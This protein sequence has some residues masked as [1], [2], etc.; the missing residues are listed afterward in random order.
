MFDSDVPLETKNPLADGNQVNR[1]GSIA[2]MFDAEVASEITKSRQQQVKAESLETENGQEGTEDMDFFDIIARAL[3]V[4]LKLDPDGIEQHLAGIFE[5]V[6][7]KSELMPADEFLSL[8]ESRLKLQLTSDEQKLLIHQV[9]G[10]RQEAKQNDEQISV[11]SLLEWWATFFEVETVDP[12]RAAVLAM[13]Q[14]NVI[15]PSSDFRGKWDLIQA[16]LLFYIACMLPYR[17]GFDHDVV[18]WSAWF[19]LDLVIDLYFVRL[20]SPFLAHQVA[21]MH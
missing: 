10:D 4:G 9:Q 2:N 12:F 11:A 18:L 5:D 19:W 1:S 20:C 17:I 7:S 13:E 3:V 21:S 14:S 16:I 6:P 15:S 8:V